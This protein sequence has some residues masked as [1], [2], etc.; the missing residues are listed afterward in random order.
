M[1]IINCETSEVHLQESCSYQPDKQNQKELGD[2]KNLTEAAVAAQ[3][4]GWRLA[5]KCKHCEKVE[6]GQ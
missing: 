3:M 4:E 1:Y 6:Q 5:T 2:F